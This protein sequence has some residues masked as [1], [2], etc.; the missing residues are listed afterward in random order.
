MAPSGMTSERLVAHTIA[1]QL[2]V[3]VEA[4][5]A[6]F[7]YALSPRAGTE[8]VAHALQSLTERE[9]TTTVMSSTAL[10]RLI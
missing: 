8:C 4:A 3:V 1:Q 9:P 5:T 7:Q 6:P 10:E 2:N